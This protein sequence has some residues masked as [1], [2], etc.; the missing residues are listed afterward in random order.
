MRKESLEF[1]F[2]FVLEILASCPFGGMPNRFFRKKGEETLYRL[3]GLYK[4]FLLL[5]DL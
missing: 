1:H 4:Y 2:Q 5:M 3:T